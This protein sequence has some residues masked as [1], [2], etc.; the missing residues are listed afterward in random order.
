MS[1]LNRPVAPDP[2]ASRLHNPGLSDRMAQFALMTG[3]VP[4]PDIVER[5]MR[6]AL[7]SVP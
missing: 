1:R 4:G 6:E 7:K 5:A 2:L 3:A